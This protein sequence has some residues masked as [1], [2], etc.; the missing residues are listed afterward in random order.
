MEGISDIYAVKADK[1]NTCTVNADYMFN[2]LNPMCFLIDGVII[3]SETYGDSLE[4]TLDKSPLKTE[5][6][7]DHPSFLTLRLHTHNLCRITIRG[8]ITSII[9]VTPT[10]TEILICELPNWDAFYFHANR[11][12]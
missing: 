11:H 9:E 3:L 6:G 7:Y 10:L 1:T 4:L 12:G 5:S 2:V 8:H